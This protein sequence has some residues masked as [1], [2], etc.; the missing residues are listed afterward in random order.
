MLGLVVE[1][2]VFPIWPI[3]MNG[4]VWPDQPF[5]SLTFLSP[6]LIA[7]LNHY[8]PPSLHKITSRFRKWSKRKWWYIYWKTMLDV[9]DSLQCRLMFWMQAPSGEW[10]FVLRLPS[11]IMKR[12]RAGPSQK[13]LLVENDNAENS[14]TRTKFIL[15]RLPVKTS[16]LQAMF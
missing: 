4:T 3:F 7:L 13:R 8:F 10:S 5:L 15:L 16:A 9:F 6:W 2:N 1:L 11:W 14:N 12:G